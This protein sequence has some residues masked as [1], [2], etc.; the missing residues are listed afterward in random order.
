VLGAQRARAL[1]DMIF[2]LDTLADIGDLVR[3]SA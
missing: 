3:A 1:A 2:R